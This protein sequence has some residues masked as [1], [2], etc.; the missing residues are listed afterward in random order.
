MTVP[1]QPGEHFPYVQHEPKLGTFEYGY[2][3]LVFGQPIRH[4]LGVVFSMEQAVANLEKHGFVLEGKQ[5]V[6]STRP[7]APKRGY[8]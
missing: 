1:R 8:A 5:L 4:R 3:E 2:A 7:A 6:M